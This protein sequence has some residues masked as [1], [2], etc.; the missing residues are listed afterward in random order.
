MLALDGK[1]I[2]H[3][4]HVNL[5]TRRITTPSWQKSMDQ[6]AKQAFRSGCLAMLLLLVGLLAGRWLLMI[7]F[8]AAF[9]E[10]PEDRVGRT[11]A[12]SVLVVLFVIFLT[13]RPK[14]KRQGRLTRRSDRP[15]NPSADPPETKSESDPGE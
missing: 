4:I 1:S 9:N 15:H 12:W 6:R 11:I 13:A 8:G 2:L 3:T 10:T 14:S 7:E 5:G